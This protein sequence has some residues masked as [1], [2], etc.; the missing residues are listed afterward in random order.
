MTGTC[1]TKAPALT[2]AWVA[3]LAIGVTAVISGAVRAETIAVDDQVSVRES[4]VDR[5]GRGM[6]MKRVEAKFGAP[7]ERHPAVGKPAIARWDYPA[8]TVFFENEYVIHAVV[9]PGS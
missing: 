6:T 9:N 2:A 1:R 5:P 4:N 8:F 3:A 7:Q